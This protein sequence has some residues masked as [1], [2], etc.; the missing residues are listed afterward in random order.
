MLVVVVDPIGM[1]LKDLLPQVVVMAEVVA[2]T[3]ITLF[4]LPWL[5]QA[6]AVAEVV[7]G[8]W[9]AVVAVRVW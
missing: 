2:H 1:V 3:Q 9:E 7:I 6:Q 8:A 4:N 5:I